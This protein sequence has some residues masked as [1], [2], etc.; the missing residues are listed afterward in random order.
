MNNATY[1]AMAAITVLPDKMEPYS[2]PALQEPYRN[3]TAGKVEEKREKGEDMQKE[4]IQG[5]SMS[6][7]NSNM[8]M[9]FPKWV[10]DLPADR[11]SQPENTQRIKQIRSDC[12]RAVFGLLRLSPCELGHLIGTLP[13]LDLPLSALWR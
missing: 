1:Y 2:N 8:P 6:S 13:T 11:N 4:Y 12:P 3:L 10:S 7:I 5:R 9:A